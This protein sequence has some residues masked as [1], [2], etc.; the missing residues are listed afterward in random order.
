MPNADRSLP[1]RRRVL[2]AG[3]GLTA[4]AAAGPALGAK[5]AL[6]P[7]QSTGPFYPR[8]LPLDSDN[9]LVTVAGRAQGAAGT[10]SHVMGRVLDSAGN[11]LGGMRVEIWQC[12][13]RGVYHHPRDSR[14]AEADHDFQG[15]GRTV[16]G[17][18]GAYRFRTIAPVPYPGRA[19][20]IHF[21]LSGR[22]LSGF[23]TQ[24]YIAG[25]PLNDG[26][27][28]LRRIPEGPARQS[29]LVEFGPGDAIEPG[30][31]LANFD[32]VLALTPET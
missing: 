12:D 10:V 19:P 16:T 27:F 30:A 11:P 14:G 15:Y 18:D 9:D 29:I 13:S 5:L 17:D 1:S 28:V 20:H 8:R 24:M 6:T 4:L 2:G 7:R 23:T 21:A 26:D 31:R 25:H 3:L 22:G 32:I